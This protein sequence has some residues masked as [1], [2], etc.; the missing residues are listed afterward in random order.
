M[1]ILI[2]GGH[3]TPAIAVIDELKDQEIIF[4]GR[5][6]SVSQETSLSFEYQEIAKRGIRFIN[7]EAGRLTRVLSVRTI[8]NLLK[9]PFGMINAYR[10][11]KIEKPNKVLSFGGYLALPIA[12]WA[13]ILKI[14]VFTHEQTIVPG[15]SN[16]LIGKFAIKIF[17]SFKEAAVFFPKGKVV[18]SGNPI[19]KAILKPLKKPLKINENL[20]TIFISGGSLGSHSI[21]KHIKNILY[22]LI[23]KYQLIHQTGSVRGKHDYKSLLKIKEALPQDLKS[24]YFLK[25]HFFEEE[26]GFIYE[27]SSLIVG[28]SGSNTFFEL[29]ALNKPAVF[30]P[31]PWAS[32]KEQQIQAEIFLK[33]GCGEIFEQSEDSSVLYEKIEKVMND[34]HRYKNNF[35]NLKSFKREDAASLI[36]QEVL[37]D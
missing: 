16:K 6:Y 26:H 4:V 37:K 20:P 3:V 18:V 8:L 27:I 28:R 19:R 15:L 11:L 30:I 29:I 32:G 10:I 14:P 13:Y 23:K 5:K 9:I 25:E 1:K 33:E 34:L 22:I 31:L 21:N 12:L 35:K 24:R 7:L 36:G 2:T 17:V